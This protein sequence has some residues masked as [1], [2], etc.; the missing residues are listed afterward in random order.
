MP[1]QHN[2]LPG[3]A[4]PQY[5]SASLS[6]DGHPPSGVIAAPASLPARAVCRICTQ[7]ITEMVMLTSDRIQVRRDRRRTLCHIRQISMYV[8]HVALQ[9]QMHDIG[10]AFGRDRP[11]VGHACHVVED[12]RD[13]PAFDDFVSAVERTVNSIFRSGGVPGHE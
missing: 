6:L 7:I 8:C 13:D 4:A 2:P 12:R 1:I 10:Q 9:I 5:L 3:A 11:T